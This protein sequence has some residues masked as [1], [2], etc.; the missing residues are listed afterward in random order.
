MRVPYLIIPLRQYLGFKPGGGGDFLYDFFY[1]ICERVQHTADPFIFPHSKLTKDSDVFDITQKLKRF[2]TMFAN[3]LRLGPPYPNLSDLS[4]IF[5][6]RKCS[7]SLVHYRWKWLLTLC[8][9]TSVFGPCCVIFYLN[10]ITF[11][12]KHVKPVSHL[13][14]PRHGVQPGCLF[15]WHLTIIDQTMGFI[16]LVTYV[17][18]E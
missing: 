15:L 12:K 14:S 17:L 11:R 18:A 7:F 10:F 9:F 4:I 13:T 6:G 8:A 1:R 5:S 2:E 16:T 3:S